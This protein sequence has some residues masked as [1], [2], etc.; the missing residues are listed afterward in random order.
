MPKTKRSSLVSPIHP[1]VRHRKL[2]HLIAKTVQ[3]QP[4]GREFLPQIARIVAKSRMQI[5]IGD[6]LLLCDRLNLNI[7]G[8]NAI[9][10]AAQSISRHLLKRLS[11]AIALTTQ[12]SQLGLSIIT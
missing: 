6:L 3:M 10:R 12:A 7:Q 8:A 2:P 9:A 4:I 11:Y 5:H 1:L